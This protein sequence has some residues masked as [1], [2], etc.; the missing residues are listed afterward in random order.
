MFVNRL[1]QA[2]PVLT[3]VLAVTTLG[4]AALLT[5]VGF[6]IVTVAGLTLAMSQARIGLITMRS[7][8]RGAVGG[9]IQFVTAGV[10]TSVQMQMM[11]TRSG[12]LSLA[13]QG[14]RARFLASAAAARAF[15]VSLLTNPVFLLIAAIVALGGELRLGVA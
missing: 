13:L 6:G 4:L 2:N 9:M 8:L 10:P 1:A 3:R 7:A 5:L 15:T 14:V 11:A 12:R